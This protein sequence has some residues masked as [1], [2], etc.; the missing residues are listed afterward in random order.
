VFTAGVDTD[1]T[2]ARSPTTEFL[3]GAAARAGNLLIDAAPITWLFGTSA[4]FDWFEVPGTPAGRAGSYVG[5]AGVFVG[6]FGGAIRQGI[7]SGVKGSASAS[8]RSLQGNWKYPGVDRFRDIMLKRGTLLFRGYPDPG[9]FYTTASAIRRSGGSAS[10]LYDGLQLAKSKNHTMR[11]S[12][13]IFEVLEDTPAAFGLAIR[14]FELG[15]G[16]L[17]QVVVPS[18][19]TSLRFLGT[20]PLRP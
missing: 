2:M 17:P 15:T 18:F 13:A 6:G 14:N 1:S 4:G 8:A 9:H 10:Y 19:E 5:N 7:G 3:Q 16:W 11:T 12:M 20:F